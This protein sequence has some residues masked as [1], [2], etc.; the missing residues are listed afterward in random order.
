MIS[1]WILKSDPIHKLPRQPIYYPIVKDLA[2]I[3]PASTLLF[4]NGQKWTEREGRI[5]GFPFKLPPFHASFY[6]GDGLHLNQGKRAAI[7]PLKDE[8]RSTRRIDVITYGFLTL[9]DRA[10]L[11][12]EA[13]LREG[14]LYDFGGLGDFGFSFLKEWSWANFCSEQVAEI[15]ESKGFRCSDKEPSETEPFRL[16]QFADRYAI[17]AQIE[18]RTV[19]LGKD[20]PAP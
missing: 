14:M 8:F 11:C 7:E 15:F 9:E 16:W 2:E 17:P 4:Y 12:R 3:P 20:F 18:I 5:K 1:W 19:H 10:M 6:L 13:R